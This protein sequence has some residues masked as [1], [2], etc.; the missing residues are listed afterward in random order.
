MAR[1]LPGIRLRIASTML[2]SPNSLMST[3]VPFGQAHSPARQWLADACLLLLAFIWGFSFVIVKQ[4]LLQVPVFYFNALRFT[5]ATVALIPLAWKTRDGWPAALPSGLILSLLLYAGF[6][7]QAS[8]LLFTTPSKSAFVT[9]SSVLW[10]PIFL[11]LFWGKKTEPPALAGIAI[12]LAGLYILSAPDAGAPYNQGDLLTAGC[13]FVWAFHVILAGRYSPL[14]PT[15]ILATLQIS[16]AAL[17]FWITAAA[18]GQ[19]GRVGSGSL[20]AILYTG[21]LCTSICLALQL[22][23]QRHVSPARAGLLL[24][25]EPLFAAVTSYF[26]IGERLTARQ[27]G[28]ALLILAG[29]VCAE[30][31]HWWNSRRQTESTRTVC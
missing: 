21:V 4:A 5:V 18:T 8:G 25:T 26:W 7:L 10:V 23:A 24:A 19:I 14:Y 6:A 13:A 12:G 29:V 17:L 30:A 1:R 28:G 31:G 22:W 2:K 16:L 11:L 27:A 9:A 3:A 20:P 15:M